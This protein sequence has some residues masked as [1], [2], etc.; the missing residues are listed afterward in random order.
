MVCLLPVLTV[1]SVTAATSILVQCTTLTASPLAAFM[2]GCTQ[3]T[4]LEEHVYLLDV[5]CQLKHLRGVTCQRFHGGTFRVG[6]AVL[7]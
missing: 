3:Q 2:S 5:P 4:M 6:A 7:S 1:L